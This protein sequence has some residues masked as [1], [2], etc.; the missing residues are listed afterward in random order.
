MVWCALRCR[1]SGKR[2]LFTFP[3]D[4]LRRQK[5]IEACNWSPGWTPSASER[6]SEVF[7]SNVQVIITV[8]LSEKASCDTSTLASC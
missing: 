4:V 7:L 5:W 3:R 1:G 8:H 6:F 2:S